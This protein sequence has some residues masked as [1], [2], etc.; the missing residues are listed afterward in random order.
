MPAAW[1]AGGQK[2][3]QQSPLVDVSRIYNRIPFGF[4]RYEWT[5]V[6]NNNGVRQPRN[7]T[8]LEGVSTVEMERFT[9]TLVQVLGGIN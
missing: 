2:K 4:V 1:L 9:S 3:L 8:C 5:P 7:G 6:E